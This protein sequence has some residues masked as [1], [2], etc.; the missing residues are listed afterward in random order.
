V[1][2]LPQ[3]LRVFSAIQPAVELSVT[4]IYYRYCMSI[5]VLDEPPRRK[6][7]LKRIGNEN[8]ACRKQFRKAVLSPR[9]ESASGWVLNE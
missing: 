1:S 2:N 3:P 7:R 6:A 5:I 8:S 9:L 4:D